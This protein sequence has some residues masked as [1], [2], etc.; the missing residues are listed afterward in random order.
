MTRAREQ[1]DGGQAMEVGHGGT[2]SRSQSACRGGE[3]RRGVV[4]HPGVMGALAT[5]RRRGTWVHR[6]ENSQ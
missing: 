5:P 1:E 3:K 2:G 4:T 6:H